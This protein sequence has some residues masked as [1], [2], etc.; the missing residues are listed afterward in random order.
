MATTMANKRKE[1]PSPKRAPKA[2]PSGPA[3]K[4]NKTS[5][6]GK[7]AAIDDYLARVVPAQRAALAR[8][9]QTI[10]KAVP[11]AEECIS[12]AVPAFRIGDKVLVG[13][14]A[15]A[16]HCS[17]FPMSGR[18]IG[19][20]AELLANYETSKGAIRFTPAAPLPDALVRKLI[21]ARLAE[22]AASRA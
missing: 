14:G 20:H 11:E 22:I 6:A 3:S 8:L 1:A 13:F 5:T 19:D 21:K 4:T 2:R 9:R 16:K 17:F 10:R 12:Y 18:T 15:S 7:G